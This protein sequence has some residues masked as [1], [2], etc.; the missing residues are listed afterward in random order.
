M[1][2]LK[3]GQKKNKDGM[4][5][6]LWVVFGMP[7]KGLSK[8]HGIARIPDASDCYTGT[9]P[10]PSMNLASGVEPR[11]SVLSLISLVGSSSRSS[12]CE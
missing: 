1:T 6:L 2:V 7:F 5:S 4:R 11:F 3:E 10:N 12:L 8:P 9:V